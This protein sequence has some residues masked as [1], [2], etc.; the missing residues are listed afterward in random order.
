MLSLQ[1][2]S[3]EVPNDLEVI[4]IKELIDYKIYEYEMKLV[5]KGIFS[6]EV[7]NV[8]ILS[9]TLVLGKHY[10]IYGDELESYINKRIFELV[11]FGYKPKTFVSP[12]V[13]DLFILDLYE[14]LHSESA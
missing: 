3:V 7:L 5:S 14:Q 2:K 13:V 6:D 4:L 11:K 12:V 8:A 1:R 9:L 10:N